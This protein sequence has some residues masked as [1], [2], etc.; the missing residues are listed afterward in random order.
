MFTQLLI[1]IVV[2]ILISVSVS[3]DHPP[4]KFINKKEYYD[5]ESDF[6]E[7]IPYWQCNENYTGLSN[8]ITVVADVR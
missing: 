7:C 2:F 4:I 6:C 3:I 1:S 8:V 5:E